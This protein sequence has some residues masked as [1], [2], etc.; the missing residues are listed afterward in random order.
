MAELKFKASFT[1][2]LRELKLLGGALRDRAGILKAIAEWLRFVTRQSF[3]QQR[4]P[5]GIPWRTLRPQYGAGKLAATGKRAM[6]VLARAGGEVF[7]FIGGKKKLFR[8]GEMFRGITSG[9]QGSTA[10]VEVPAIYA[11]AHQFGH[12]YPAMTIRAKN[13]KALAIPTALG[14]ILRKSAKIPA[15][16][17]PARPF[18]PGQMMAER[19]GKRIIELHILEGLRGAGAK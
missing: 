7:Q 18:V 1:E 6:R 17:L 15:R 12:T 4:S 2:A 5:E 11:A 10:F 14:V 3:E 8:S 9:V 13:A 19:E 16:T